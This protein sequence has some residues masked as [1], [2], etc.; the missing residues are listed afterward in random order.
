M[1][2]W[3]EVL[4]KDI[5][6]YSEDRVKLDQINLVNYISTENMNPNREGIT[7]ATSLPAAKTVSGY[8]SNDILISNIRP[9]FKKIWFADKEGGCSND[10]LVIRNKHQDQVDSK[11]LYYSLFTDH[12]FDYVMTGAKGAKMPRGDKEE[13]MKYPLILP[14]LNIQK[15]IVSILSN[16]D[17]KIQINLKMNKT[18]EETAMALYKHWFVD[19]GQFHEEE[20]V[21][22]E[23]GMIPKGWDVGTLGDIYDTSSGGTPSR[24]KEEYYKEGKINW[25]KTKELKDRYVFDT[26]EKITELGLMKS[27]AK[28]FPAG[29]VII[30][31]YGATVGQLGILAK[32]TSTN[33]ACC[34]I[35]QGNNVFPPS[36]A[37]LYL[38]N[39]REK[40]INLA[41]GGAQ[42]NINQQIIKSLPV[43]LP[44]NEIMLPMG[45]KL[46]IL[47]QLKK[48]NEEVILT[49]E[50]ARDYL[51]S[52][53]LSGE[54]EVSKAVNIVREVI[55]NEQPEPSV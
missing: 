10:V 33:Q 12:F 49:L 43:V 26:E 50:N 48:R 14:P 42:Q 17:D 8:S 29:T 31:M 18:L 23:I 30:A 1:S 37:Y 6:S 22:S 5:S 41:N 11:F 44:P 35:L 54:I 55:S 53:L 15:K 13:I 34:A 39:N 28:L 16:I 7:I 2:E 47:F 25:L 51:L 4:L 38:L 40:I 32:E 9:Y 19:F 52:R 36:F 3:R 46:E 45:K 27:S 20:F 21:S 24:K